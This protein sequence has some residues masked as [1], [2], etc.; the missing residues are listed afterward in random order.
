MAGYGMGSHVIVSFLA[1]LFHYGRGPFLFF[2]FIISGASSARMSSILASRTVGTSQRILAASIVTVIHM[3]FLLYL[4]FSYHHIV[5]V[6]LEEVE[7]IEESLD[8][9]FDLNL[10]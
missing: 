2:W 9:T 7:S 3:T 5:D 6:I 1:E 8:L 4:H 10:T